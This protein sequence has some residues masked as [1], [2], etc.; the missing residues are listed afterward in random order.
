[1]AMAATPFSSVEAAG[2]D[3]FGNMGAWEHQRFSLGTARAFAA[4]VTM[5]RYVYLSG[6]TDGTNTLATVER[7]RILDPLEVPEL[8]IND[9]VPADAGLDA[10]YWIYR[11]SATFGAADLDNPNGESLASDPIIVKLPAVAGKKI[12]VL[13]GWSPPVDSLGAPL[14]NVSGYRIYRTPTVNGVSGEEVR[15]AEI[16]AGMTTYTDDGTA[17]PGSDKPLPTG[18]TGAWRTLPPMNS[19]RKGHAAAVAF[20]PADPTKHTFYVYS[21]L[22][23]NDVGTTVASYEYLPVTIE[24]NGRQTVGT[25]SPGANSFAAARW[26]MSAW[27]TDHT[28]STLIPADDTWIYVGGGLSAAAMF[29]GKVEAGKVAAGGDL[30]TISDVPKDFTSSAAGYGVCAANGQ[31]FQFGGQNATPSSGAKAATLTTPVPTLTNQSWN[32]EGLTMTQSRYLMGSAVQSAFIFLVGGQTSNSPAS[33][34]TELVV[35]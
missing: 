22:G 1:M 16:A 30:G 14:P 4:G 17:V 11:V 34:T 33:Q 32:A 15:I 23:M 13:L 12:Q 25:W 27:T 18:S 7:A 28:V 2:V 24:P 19:P 3:L 20:D 35:W 21:L 5:G 31:L 10:G 8:N 9:I 29:S 6:G 26:Q